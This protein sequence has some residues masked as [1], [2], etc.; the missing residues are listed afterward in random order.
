MSLEAIQQSLD[1]LQSG[2]LDEAA[3]LRRLPAVRLP[4]ELPRNM[5]RS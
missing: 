5:A 1:S 3:L 4:P 2:T